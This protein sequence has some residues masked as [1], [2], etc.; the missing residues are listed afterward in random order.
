MGKQGESIQ[1]NAAAK[2]N[3]LLDIVH[4]RTDGYHDLF[5]VMQSVDLYDRVTITSTG[6]GQI[7]LGCSEAAL[8]VDESNIAFRAALAFFKET[9]LQNKGVFIQIEKHIPFA[10]GLAGGSADGAAVLVGL[11]ALYEAGLNEEQLCRI[12]VQIGADVPFCIRG[13]TMLAQGIGDVLH[14]LKPLRHCYIVLAKPQQGVNTAKAYAAYDEN[15]RQYEP[16][17]LGMLTAVQNRDLD[18]IGSHMANVFEQFIEVPDRIAIR[19]IMDSFGAKGV[20]MSGSGP[21]VLGLFAERDQAA[22]CAGS[23]REQMREVFVCRPARAGCRP[24]SEEDT[25]EAD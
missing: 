16:D 8:P 23:L 17:K 24:A 12:G 15:G 7:K 6:D 11:N 9:K 5:M 22:A 13:G 2:I 20:C 3:L 19:K 1:V 4:R 21:T 10:A 14:P 18:G 25:N